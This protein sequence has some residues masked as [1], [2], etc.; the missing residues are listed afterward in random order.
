MATVVMIYLNVGSM[1][2]GKIKEIEDN[3]GKIKL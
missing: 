2:I 1:M 3:V